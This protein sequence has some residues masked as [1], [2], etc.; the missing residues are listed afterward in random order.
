MILHV[1]LSVLLG[2]VQ[3]VAQPPVAPPAAPPAV[4]PAAPS[5]PAAPEVK[6]A[7][8]APAEPAGAKPAA[9]A[10]LDLLE[11]VSR[12]AVEKHAANFIVTQDG[13]YWDRQLWLERQ[14]LRDRLKKSSLLPPTPTNHQRA[15]GVS[16]DAPSD[17]YDHID[18]IE[19]KE[20][21]IVSGEVKKGYRYRADHTNPPLWRAVGGKACI[22]AVELD[23]ARNAHRKK[24]SVAE[25]GAAAK[26]APVAPFREVVTAEE[27][28]QAIKDGKAE[29]SEFR[30]TKR[31]IE[32]SKIERRDAKGL[33]TQSA[34]PEDAE[35]SWFRTEV[36]VRWLKEK[37]AAPGDG[38]REVEGK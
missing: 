23:D 36:P 7:E 14:E 35:Y 8:P 26:D 18:G 30:W 20:W 17:P 27:L 19:W 29:L 3:T 28:A 22:T 25:Q 31:V 37:P 24:L 33:V 12:R 9:S 32:K 21:K 4:P 34:A 2:V 11:P 15:L 5:A 13:T 16:K 1:V 6:P 38:K 10:V